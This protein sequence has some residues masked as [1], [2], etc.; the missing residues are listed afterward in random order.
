M[1]NNYKLI[2]VAVVWVAFLLGLLIVA[3]SKS[4]AAKSVNEVRA[5]VVVITDSNPLDDILFNLEPVSFISEAFFQG[6]GC[7]NPCV[8]SY[9]SCQRKKGRYNKSCRQKIVSCWTACNRA[10]GY[11][12]PVPS[13]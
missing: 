2:A 1:Q 11:N 8:R 13:P 9:R 5:G 7:Y 3:P 4:T 10:V 6:S 12:N